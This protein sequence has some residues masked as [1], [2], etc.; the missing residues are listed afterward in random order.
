MAVV[1]LVINGMLVLSPFDQHVCRHV[2]DKL[3][4]LLRGQAGMW[5]TPN[6]ILE[7]LIYPEDRTVNV[8]SS[9]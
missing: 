6:S 2:Q 7:G 9:S 4:V 5:A 3:Y 1:F 8:M